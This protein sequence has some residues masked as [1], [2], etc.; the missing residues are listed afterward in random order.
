[1]GLTRRRRPEIAA[2]IDAALKSGSGIGCGAGVAASEKANPPKTTVWEVKGNEEGVRIFV[3]H[4]QER[5]QYEQAMRERSMEKVRVELESLKTEVSK[6]RIKSPQQIGA[7]AGRILA[8]NK[9]SGYYGWSLS[10]KGAFE[11]FEHPA[12]FE[13]EKK[14]E[15]KY[16]IQT[17]E[18]NITAAEAVAQYKELSE[19]ERGFRSLKDV[20][21]LRPIYHQKDSR[22]QA[23]I[24]V[25]ALAF[26]LERVLEKK[27]APQGRAGPGLSVTDALNALQT[28]CAMEFAVGGKTGRG[29]TSGDARARQVLAVLGVSNVPLPGSPTARRPMKTRM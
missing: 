13:L 24:F 15:G 18:Q 19:V 10:E 4:S 3:V 20:I 28:I 26:L 17:E 21:E 23:H 16:L 9:G 6:G 27:L 11:Y 29:V 2:Y 8:R 12:H 1:M 7:R 5:Q 14:I 22:V 25:A